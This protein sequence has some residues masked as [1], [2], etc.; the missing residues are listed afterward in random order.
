[1]A[2]MNALLKSIMVGI[3]RKTSVVTP[4]SRYMKYFCPTDEMSVNSSVEEASD[5]VIMKV[6]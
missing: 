5:S 6:N 4:R 2:C 1:M 3:K